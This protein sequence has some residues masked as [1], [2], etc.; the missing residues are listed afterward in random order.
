MTVGT[1]FN[2]STP[3]TQILVF[4]YLS[5]ALELN[6]VIEVVDKYLEGWESVWC[7]LG[8]QVLKESDHS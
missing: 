4:I 6:L 7:K 3:Y 2:I 8:E 5:F 1:L